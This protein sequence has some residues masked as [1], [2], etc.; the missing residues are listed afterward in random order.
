[1]SYTVTD[2][3]AIV[4]IGGDA[5]V[6]AVLDTKA[7]S[8]LADQPRYRTAIDRAGASNAGQVYV[9]LQAIVTAAE[10]SLPADAKASY[11]RDVKP[12]LAP[13]AAFAAVSQDGDLVHGRI[14]V[15]VTK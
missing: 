1:L 9:D 11:D 15:T 13:F 5:F 2:Q 10:G 3:F 14:V 6:K 4:G 7:G 12:Y 8:S